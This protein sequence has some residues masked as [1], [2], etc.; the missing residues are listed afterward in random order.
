MS[1]KFSEKRPW[2]QNEILFESWK[3]EFNFEGHFWLKKMSKTNLFS[4]E[5]FE[6]NV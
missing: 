2:F 3:Q 4:T 5:I 6:V 1:L